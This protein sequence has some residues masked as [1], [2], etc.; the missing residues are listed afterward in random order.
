[1]TVKYIFLFLLLS[2]NISA[3]A[4]LTGTVVAENNNEPV[5]SASVFLSNTSIGTIT[6]NKGVFVLNN[7]PEGR[8]DLVV[9]CI[10]FETVITTVSSNKIPSSLTIHLKPKAKELDEVVVEQYVKN[11]WEQWGKFFTENLIGTSNLANDC[12]F[13]NH[14]VV[15]F[16]YNKKKR[17]LKAFADEALIIENKALGYHLS[18]QLTKF[19]YNFN[20]NIFYF[21]GY[22]LFSNMLTKRSR[23]QNRWTTNRKN[24]YYGSQMHFMRSVFRNKLMEEGFEVRRL[25]KISANEHQRVKSI[26]SSLTI[27]N[28][29]SSK[30]VDA[31]DNPDSIVYYKKVLHNPGGFDVLINT[32]MPGDSIAY[33]IDKNTAGLEFNNYLQVTFTK[34]RT[35]E[36]YMNYQ[37]NDRSYGSVISEITL[38]NKRG[39]AILANG[40]FYE[41]LDLISS[42][43]WAWWEKLGNM[44]PLEYWPD[45]D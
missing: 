16:S 34:R 17:I 43:F 31:T 44:L 10:G 39:V 8:F 7:F 45:K 15:K 33:A 30:N 9:S 21:Q 1:M 27:T 40:S 13:K 5:A 11:G 38:P 2:I 4:Q 28:K 18:Y 32:I 23:L 12:N 36:G 41:G 22:P 24:A 26:Y 20:T 25:I 3:K 6:N 37:P 29:D 35:P 42:G 19:E 14:K